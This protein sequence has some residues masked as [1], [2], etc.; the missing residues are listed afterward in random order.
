MEQMNKKDLAEFMA[1][2]AERYEEV[3]GGT[4]VDQ[5]LDELIESKLASG[6]S[7]E[8]I[9][10]ETTKDIKGIENPYQDGAPLE[11]VPERLSLDPAFVDKFTKM[12]DQAE[13]DYQ[14]AQAGGAAGGAKL[15]NP[16]M[17]N[18]MKNTADPTPEELEAMRVSDPA[19]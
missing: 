19:A 15:Y 4:E 6:M 11:L 1:D 18:I 7:F 3:F 9:L 16:E 2:N 5:A 14:R 10:A 12:M 8:D 13:D 17:M